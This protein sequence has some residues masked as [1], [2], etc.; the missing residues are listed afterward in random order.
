MEVIKILELDSPI[1]QISLSPMDSDLETKLLV[2]TETRTIVCDSVEQTFV[3]IGN[4][5]R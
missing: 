1:V 2:S 5:T 3:E 4:Q